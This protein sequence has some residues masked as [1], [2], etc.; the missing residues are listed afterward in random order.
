MNLILK[1]ILE[2]VYCDESILHCLKGTPH[3]VRKIWCILKNIW[4]SYI[5]LPNDYFPGKEAEDRKEI[6]K[7]DCKFFVEFGRCFPNVFPKPCG[8][9]INMMPFVSGGHHFE[10]FKLPSILRPYIDILRSCNLAVP[11][12][13]QGK[14]KIF[15][16]TIQEGWVEPNESQRRAGIFTEKT[17]CILVKGYGKLSPMNGGGNYTDRLMVVDGFVNRSC[18]REGG[19]FIGSSVKNGY[20][21]NCKVGQSVKDGIDIID[22]YGSCEHLE[23]FLPRDEKVEMEA[24][25][26]Y[27]I[28]D[29]TPQE[30]LPLKEKTYCQFFK[31]VSDNVSLW[32]ADHSTPNP[33]GVLPDPNITKIV[34]GRDLDSLEIITNEEYSK[35]KK[36]NSSFN[37]LFD[38]SGSSL[39][40]DTSQKIKYFNN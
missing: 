17:G 16:L 2:G 15:Y 32:F 13:Y 19:I 26:L 39:G 12:N 6:I 14:R 1:I 38:E 25:T 30:W 24:N 7:L 9:S 34:K 33:Y 35:N 27:W 18:D 21:W 31:V 4:K 36:I 37:F 40:I 8:I 5:K 28:T 20:L 29:R 22:K 3:I 11:H 23:E 10:E